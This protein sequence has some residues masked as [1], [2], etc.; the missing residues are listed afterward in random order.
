[1][2]IP[3]PKLSLHSQNYTVFLLGIKIL[4]QILKCGGNIYDL[5][6]SKYQ[7]RKRLSASLYQTVHLRISEGKTRFFL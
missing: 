3:K 5:Q 2:R 1:M 6:P 7:S 4:S